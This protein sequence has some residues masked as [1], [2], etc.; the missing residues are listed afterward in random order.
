LKVTVCDQQESG[1]SM[2]S[3]DW[4]GE[5]FRKNIAGT[6]IPIDVVKKLIKGEETDPMEF[7]SK[8]G[9][10]FSARLKLDLENDGKTIFIFN[11]NQNNHDNDDKG[12]N[13]NGS[14]DPDNVVGYCPAC[15]GEVVENRKGFGCIN[16][17]N[18]CKFV[19][20]KN[21]AG[22]QIT[23]EIAER[24]LDGV[25]TGPMEFTS[26]KGKPFSASLVLNEE[27]D[28]WGAKFVFNEE[29]I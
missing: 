9:K 18:G 7:T 21:I 5:Y 19:I 8:K 10:P 26:K 17:Q 14:T 2:K 23:Q 22:T 3:T 25:T 12:A 27:N 6:Q 4:C 28:V 20:W 16:W 11:D 13:A 15:G 29:M 1:I 24:L